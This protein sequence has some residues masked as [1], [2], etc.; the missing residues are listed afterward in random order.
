VSAQQISNSGVA[1]F[2][3]L[4]L[5][6]IAGDQKSLKLALKRLV[7]DGPASAVRGAASEID[8]E[9]LTRS[10]GPTC[11][12]FLE[13]G[14]D[15]FTTDDAERAVTFLLRLIDDPAEFAERTTP[16]Y[17]VIVQAL[18]S[19]AGVIGAAPSPLSTKPQK[20]WSGSRHR[21]IS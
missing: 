4:S 16:H 18:E 1:A 3:E 11:L 8:Y 14:G 13:H 5:L 6:R 21:S 10:T 7:L 2:D 15:V 17:H 12:S 9:H 19:L 20:T